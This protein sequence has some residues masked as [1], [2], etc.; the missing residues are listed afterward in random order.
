VKLGGVRRDVEALA[1][2][3]VESAVDL[4][5]TRGLHNLARV[6]KIAPMRAP[7]RLFT[8]RLQ[9]D[10]LVIYTPFVQVQLNRE[11]RVRRSCPLR[12][13]ERFKVDKPPRRPIVLH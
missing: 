9:Q 12:V 7:Q 13:S 6:F 4:S 5:S 3:L 8:G 1:E 2:D 10:N 11:S